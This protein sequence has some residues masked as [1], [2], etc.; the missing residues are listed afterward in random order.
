MATVGLP[1]AP[2]DIEPVRSWRK[3][4]AL[5]L[6]QIGILLGVRLAIQRRRNEHLRR[7]RLAFGM[8]DDGVDDLHAHLVRKLNRVGVDFA[9]L[10]RLLALGLA[11]EADND[12]L[13]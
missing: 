4:A 10:D 8:A 11:V 13:L 12:D 6:L 2:C 5:M 3:L 7:Q 9:V 1:A